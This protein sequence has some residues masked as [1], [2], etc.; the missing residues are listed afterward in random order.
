MHHTDE[1]LIVDGTSLVT[2]APAST[3]LFQV[4]AQEAQGIPVQLILVNVL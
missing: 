4:L 1:K 3:L 2:A